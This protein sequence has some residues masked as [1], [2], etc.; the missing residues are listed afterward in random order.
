MIPVHL[1]D[2]VV[3]VV[4]VDHQH[5]RPFLPPTRHVQPEMDSNDN[6]NETTLTAEVEERGKLA[7]F[8]VFMMRCWGQV[9]AKLGP[10]WG[11]VVGPNDKTTTG[12]RRP[13]LCVLLKLIEL[14]YMA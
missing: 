13:S 4:V 8:F 7:R 1:F 10:S 14:F 2:V 11:R 6:N 3:V 12:G 9:E 5:G